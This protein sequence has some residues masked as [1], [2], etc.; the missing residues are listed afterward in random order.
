MSN[1]VHRLVATIV[2]LGLSIGASATELTTKC[3]NGLSVSAKIDPLVRDF[4]MRDKLPHI[5]GSVRLQNDS[6][7][8]LVF[9]TS[10]LL[11]STEGRTPKRAYINSVASQLADFS[12]IKIQKGQLV[13]LDVYWPV[14]LA[15]GVT[16]KSLELSCAI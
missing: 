9:S 11:L 2:F 16:I 10:K 5:N 12:S 1:Y 13:T 4:L 14:S 15:V 3:A 7:A 6:K 8:A